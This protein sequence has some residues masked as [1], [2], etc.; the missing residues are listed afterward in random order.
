MS[1]VCAKKP[2]K[3]RFDSRGEERRYSSSAACGKAKDMKFFLFQ[4]PAKPRFDGRGGNGMRALP[5]AAKR[6]I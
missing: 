5:L 1:P 4:K 2:I 3:L 6:R